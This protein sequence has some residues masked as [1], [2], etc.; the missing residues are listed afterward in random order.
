MAKLGKALQ[1]KARGRIGNI[2]YSVVKGQQV[3]REL[4]V[5]VANPRTDQQMDQRTRLANIVNLY[6]VN[7][8]WM[9][10]F[11]FET[12]PQTQSDYNAFVAANLV[13]GGPASVY[14]TKQEAALG[15]AVASPLTITKGS[16]RGIQHV[17]V[18]DT[19]VVRTNI[20]LGAVSV[21]LA[22]A[23]VAEVSALILANNNGFRYGDFLSL[24]LNIQQSDVTSGIPYV[25]ERQYQ[26]TLSGTDTTPFADALGNSGVSAVLADGNYCLAYEGND[27][28]F[29][30]AFV[31]SRYEGGETKVSSQTFCL[32]NSTYY[33]LYSTLNQREKA[34]R[35]Y[36]ETSQNF[37]SGQ[38]RNSENISL[39]QSI[40][41]VGGIAAGAYYGSIL[42]HADVTSQ[43][44]KTLTTIVMA[45]PVSSTPSVSILPLNGA[46]PQEIDAANVTYSGSQIV[47]D[48]NSM[49]SSNGVT[50]QSVNVTIGGDSYS[51][52]FATSAGNDDNAEGQ[53]E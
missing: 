25:V 27:T 38:G 49:G 43:P 26:V 2:V 10:K 31:H 32:I 19:K 29:A 37:L 42:S 18:G 15:A 46:Q 33:D 14:L 11:G 39:T 20:F 23:T 21:N 48:T 12:K 8:P 17:Q 5:Q 41:S 24:I 52:T 22:T 40:L 7:K 45:A 34:F 4:A 51:I 13:T 3:A 16:L 44:N 35:S 47:F 30:V 50:L 1:T 36:G 9:V 53:T 28:A 6:R